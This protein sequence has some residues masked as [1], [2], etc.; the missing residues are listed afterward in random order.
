MS[1]AFVND[2]TPP[3]EILPQHRELVPQSEN[4][5]TRQGQVS[6]LNELEILQS[7][8]TTPEAKAR[9]ARL[10]KILSST[11]VLIPE[12]KNRD[13][14]LFGAQVTLED[15]HGDFREYKL[16]GLDETDAKAGK[17]S[18]ISPIGKALLQK[19]VG[20][21]VTVSTPRKIEE[22]EVKAIRYED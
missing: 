14:V 21:L 2:N 17:I 3:L 11:Q 7:G 22:F 16:V 20:D 8:P 1:K 13:R 10:E 19:E 12:K 5:I 4:Y 6:F 9:I 15:E 18:W